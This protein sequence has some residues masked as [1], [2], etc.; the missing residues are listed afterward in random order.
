M[1]R[2]VDCEDDKSLLLHH[3]TGSGGLLCC[4]GFTWETEVEGLDDCNSNSGFDIA[5]SSRVRAL[6]FFTENAHLVLT[7][8]GCRLSECF[9]HC[10]F[11]G[12]LLLHARIFGQQNDERRISFCVGEG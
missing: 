7:G 5:T 2:N 6:P 4:K 10:S 1:A 12:V 3:P 8:H 11:W 9:N